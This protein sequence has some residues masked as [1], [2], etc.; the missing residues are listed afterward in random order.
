M[1]QSPIFSQHFPHLDT[2]YSSINLLCILNEVF[3]IWCSHGTRG[4]PT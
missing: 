1:P 2:A 3:E 4:Y